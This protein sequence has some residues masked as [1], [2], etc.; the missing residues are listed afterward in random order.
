[1]GTSQSSA[2]R[3]F[4]RYALAVGLVCGSVALPVSLAHAVVIGGCTGLKHCTDGGFNL[5]NAGSQTSDAPEWAG[6][7]VSKTFFPLALDGSGGAYLYVEQGITGQP[8]RLYLMYDYVA[9]TA[10]ESFFNVFFQVKDEDYLAKIQG[11]SVTVFVKPADQPSSLNPDGTF[12]TGAPWTAADSDDLALGNFKGSVSFGVSPNSSVPHPLAEFEVS[13]DEAAFGAGH[14]NSGTG[15]YDP[16]PAFWSASV[17]K[18]S[19]P[20]DPPISSGIFQLNSDGGVGVIPVLGPNGGPVIQGNVEIPEPGGVWMM[21]PAL[22]L[23]A[24]ATYR[25]THQR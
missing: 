19:G 5:H 1:M 10:A 2:A 21:G 6:P 18:G 16:S 15:L 17:P 8:N 3:A 4:R 13:I 25:Q 14:P 11:T 22:L 23:L 24:G 12:N 7:N 20:G 9:G